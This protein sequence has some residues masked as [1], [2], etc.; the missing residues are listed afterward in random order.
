MLRAL[1]EEAASKGVTDAKNLLMG[2]LYA[3]SSLCKEL[4]S[5]RTYDKRSSTTPSVPHGIDRDF[6]N[7]AIIVSERFLNVFLL[8]LNSL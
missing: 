6:K 8:K 5:P 4:E 1:I 7:L 2:E 3:L